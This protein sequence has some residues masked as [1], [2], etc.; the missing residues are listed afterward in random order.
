MVLAPAERDVCAE[1]D[2]AQ[3]RPQTRAGGS[4]Q[5]AKQTSR[6]PRPTRLVAQS[7]GATKRRWERVFGAWRCSVCY[8]RSETAAG[9]SAVDL[10][11][12]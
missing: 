1:S 11:E 10:K 5:Q 3:I 4:S 2:A 12:S 8:E 6:G 7:S 9:F